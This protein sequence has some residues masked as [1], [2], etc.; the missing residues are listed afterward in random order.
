M[1]PSVC[2]WPLCSCT[3]WAYFSFCTDSKIRIVDLKFDVSIP[4][5]ICYTHW[6]IV[7]FSVSYS[8]TSPLCWNSPLLLV[9]HCQIYWYLIY[10]EAIY[11]N[12]WFCTNWSSEGFFPLLIDI[13]LFSRR[14]VQNID[15][16][17]HVSTAVESAVWDSLEHISQ[18]HYVDPWYEIKMM[19]S[20][21]PDG[22]P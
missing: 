22:G 15:F 3:W 13:Q 2:S 20:E 7:R 5:G 17:S 9:L 19:G 21:I 10:L 1:L 16:W 8:L 6:N 12:F 11:S 4:V 18:I 14:G